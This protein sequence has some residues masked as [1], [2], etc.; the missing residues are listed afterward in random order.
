MCIRRWVHHAKM[1]LRVPVGLWGRWSKPFSDKI[2][3]T[4]TDRIRIQTIRLRRWGRKES[5]ALH[6]MQR[7]YNLSFISI[8]MSPKADIGAGIVGCLLQ[9]SMRCIFVGSKRVFYCCTQSYRLSRERCIEVVEWSRS[10][11]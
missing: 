5:V 7:S 10:A 6:V 2:F 11:M 9:M 3:L 4:L 1:K 8:G